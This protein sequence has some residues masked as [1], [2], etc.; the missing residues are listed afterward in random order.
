MSHATFDP[1]W[2]RLREPLDGA[3]R[4]VEL[5]WAFGRSLPRSP[6]LIDLG[7]GS[8]ANLRHLAPRIGRAEQDWTLVENDPAL[9]EAAPREIA[10]WAAGSGHAVAEEGGS[11]ALRSA[12]RSVRVRMRPC[13]LAGG[14]P[15]L[16]FREADG[17]TASALL[18][19]ASAAWVERFAD[20][21]AEAGL[22]P[23]LLTLTVDG[24]VRFEE[25]D[26]DDGFV[27]G[28]VEDHM[29]RDK[30]FGP[31][32]GGAAPAAAIDA[33]RRVGYQVDA[34]RADWR[35]GPREKP[36]HLALL[37]GYE[38]AA[39]EQAPASS[40]RIREW[41]ARRRAVAGDSGL[42]VGHTDIL[43]VR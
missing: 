5:T 42:L 6:R 28:L 33:L 8:G 29:G 36:V 23:V 35:I 11:L 16:D 10:A 17:I 26:P 12:D 18:D 39:V 15:A 27:L 31:A 4:A 2:L 3:A 19:L 30:G 7:A 34:A 21:L 41:A 32:L 37:D 13:D 38:G 40:G 25:P 20:A 24:R 43:A 22:P 9:L 1:G 14:L